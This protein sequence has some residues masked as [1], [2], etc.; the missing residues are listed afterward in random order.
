MWNGPYAS[1]CPVGVALTPRLDFPSLRSSYM[2]SIDVHQSKAPDWAWYR[3]LLAIGILSS[4][5]SL[6]PF[7]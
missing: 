5:L 2:V 3:R 4:A 1:A 6:Q 7:P